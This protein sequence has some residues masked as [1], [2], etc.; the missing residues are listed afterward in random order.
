M[1]FSLGRQVN[2]EAIR[3]KPSAGLATK[4]RV[5]RVTGHFGQDPFRP[6][7]NMA[8]SMIVSANKM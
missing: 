5:T 4:A 8:K 6:E 3:V 2:A 1:G 7:K